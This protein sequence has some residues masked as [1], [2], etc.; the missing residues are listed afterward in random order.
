M[1]KTVLL[2]LLLSNL[3]FA[4]EKESCEKVESKFNESQKRILSHAYAYGKPY[5][6]GY[7]LAAIAWEESSAGEVLLNPKDPSAGIYQN[8]VVYALKREGIKNNYANRSDMLL[9]L[10]TNELKSTAHGISELVHWVGRRDSWK[11]VWASYNGGVNYKGKQARD[12]AEKVYSKLKTLKRCK[13]I[14]KLKSLSELDV[15]VFYEVERL[16]NK[17]PKLDVLKVWRELI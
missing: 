9:Q 13:N 4:G 10:A 11:E 17:K 2:S 15:S 16:E 5:D 1:K 7:S 14:L 6:V 3:A 12:Y 8:H